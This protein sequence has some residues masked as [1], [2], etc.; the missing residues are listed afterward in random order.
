MESTIGPWH[1]MQIVTDFGLNGVKTFYLPDTFKFNIIREVT[2]LRDCCD[3]EEAHYFN[4][5]KP[6]IPKGTTLKVKY[7]WCNFYGMFYR[8]FY[9][10]NEYDIKA[11]DVKEG[12]LCL[13]EFIGFLP[14]DYGRSYWSRQDWDPRYEHYQEIDMEAYIKKCKESLKKKDE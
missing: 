12:P 2:L 11:S 1:Q 7:R 3:E 14:D 10:G 9:N 6:W 4:I 5:T 8:C 13:A